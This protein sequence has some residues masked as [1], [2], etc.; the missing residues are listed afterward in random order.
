MAR[1]LA[2]LDGVA[3]GA[4]NTTEL[5]AVS[6]KIV[7][8]TPGEASGEA[9]TKGQLDAVEQS[10]ENLINNVAT[11]QKWRKF[12]TIVTNDAAPLEDA[13]LASVLPFS[14]DAAPQLEETDI[15]VGDY[16]AFDVEDTPVIG[17][18]IDDEGTKRVTFIDV[19]Q[20]TEGDFYG[21]KYNLLAGTHALETLAIYSMNDGIFEKVAA[22]AWDLANAIGLATWSPDAGEIT[23]ND[24]VNSALEKSVGNFLE[25]VSD[26][27]SV[28]N[29]K[30]A[31]LVGIEDDGDYF[32]GDN[33]EDVL[34]EIGAE[35]QSLS[36]G[37]AESETAKAVEFDGIAGETLEVNKTH[38]VRYAKFGET[39]GRLYKAIADSLDNAEVV[40]FVT[41][42]AVEVSASDEIKVIESGEAVLGSADTNFAAEQE[43]KPVFLSQDVAGEVVL[44]AGLSETTGSIIKRVGTTS[45]VGAGSK[46]RTQNYMTIQA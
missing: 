19:R 5:D 17:Q 37:V 38:A 34:Q 21:V 45:I 3:V 8:L 22:F 10:L 40:G 18:V 25:F 14:D 13:T 36:E 2:L 11:G 33:A 41:V 4:G 43:N 44:Y 6:K 9:S 20:P 12:L 30:G 29:G 24:T 39:A 23:V 35:L 1:I 27:A 42:G 16:L 26:L 28:E 7:N 15:N 31:S 32:V 46:F